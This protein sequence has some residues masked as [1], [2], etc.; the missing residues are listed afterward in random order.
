MCNLSMILPGHTNA[1][2]GPCAPVI[3]LETFLSD[4]CYGIINNDKRPARIE[5]RLRGV[6]QFGSHYRTP[7]EAISSSKRS[8]PSDLRLHL[9]Y[10][11]LSSYVEASLIPTFTGRYRRCVMWIYKSEISSHFITD[12]ARQATYS[13][14]T[15]R[16][17]RPAHVLP[18]HTLHPLPLPAHSGGPSSAAMR[19]RLGCRR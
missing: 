4:V 15:P 2:R 17:Q 19:G 18:S 1:P 11:L 7:F 8:D 12:Q 14:G 6:S 3:F 9:V 10:T 13:A 5:L 16:A